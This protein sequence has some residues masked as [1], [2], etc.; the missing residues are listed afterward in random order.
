[1]PCLVRCETDEW[2]FIRVGDEL[3]RPCSATPAQSLYTIVARTEGYTFAA[4]VWAL[5]IVQRP[6]SVAPCET[7]I[8][9]IRNFSTL[10]SLTPNP[11]HQGDGRRGVGGEQPH[12][13]RDLIDCSSGDIPVPLHDCSS[14]RGL[15]VRRESVGAV[16]RSRA[17]F[18]RA[19]RNPDR[20]RLLLHCIG[21]G[22][23]N[24]PR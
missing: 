9:T 16:H 17:K 18:C 12:C 22:M 10:W 7:L 8:V 23:K 13:A 15:H 11:T 4:K 19:V 3:S 24:V 1:M 2:G 6:V 20:S 21:I 14:Y 5:S